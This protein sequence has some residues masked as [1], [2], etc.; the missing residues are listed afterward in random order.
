M[1]QFF[2]GKYYHRLQG[3][4]HIELTIYYE[5]TE[6]YMYLVLQEFLC[7]VFRGK[8]SYYRWMGCEF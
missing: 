2:G 1:L 8:D 6:K 7:N 3:T 5:S 4:I